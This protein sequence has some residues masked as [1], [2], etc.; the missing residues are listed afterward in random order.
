[1]R[2]EACDNYI[3]K[4]S[5]S[6]LKPDGCMLVNYPEL[7]AQ[8][9]MMLIDGRDLDNGEGYEGLGHLGSGSMS[10]RVRST[11]DSMKVTFGNLEKGLQQTVVNLNEGDEFELDDEVVSDDATAL[12]E[13]EAIRKFDFDEHL[14]DV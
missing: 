3:P 10:V 6:L 2:W 7:Q 14:E 11:P 8:D 9:I 5:L 1:M 13:G 12:T 4:K